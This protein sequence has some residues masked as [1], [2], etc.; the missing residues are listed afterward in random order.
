LE[1]Q[2]RLD[3][4]MR[5]KERGSSNRETRIGK[6][7]HRDSENDYG[8]ENSLSLDPEGNPKIRDN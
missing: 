3:K 7:T 2:R 1:R 5:I 6:R 4:R 8:N